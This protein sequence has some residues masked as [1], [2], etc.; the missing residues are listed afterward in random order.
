MNDLF[1]I[2]WHNA[3][4]RSLFKLHVC[5]C[6]FLFS[7]Q[8]IALS[9]PWKMFFISS[10]KLFSFSRY[11]DFYISVFDSF[12]PVSHCFRDWSKI[13]LEIYYLINCLRKKI[14]TYFLWYLEKEKRF[15]IETLSIDRVLNKD[16]FYGKILQKIC[17]KSYSQTPF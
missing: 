2:A 13:N 8:M 16:Y 14:I 17:S 6:Y 1:I 12:F 15:D 10:K 5:G 9:K 11:S 3:G 7:H 4:H